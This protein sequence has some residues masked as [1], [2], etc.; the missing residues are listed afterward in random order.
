MG[1]GGERG[2]LDGAAC[3]EG[4][5]ASYIG[6]V[7]P[8]AGLLLLRIV[9]S[10]CCVFVPHVPLTYGTPVPYVTSLEIILCSR[11]IH[12]LFWDLQTQTEYQYFQGL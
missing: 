5:A 4:A 6:A 12:V 1:A 11:Q 2:G 9:L 10:A 3:V 8:A 7:H